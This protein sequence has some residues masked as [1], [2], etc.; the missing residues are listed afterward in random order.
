MV[1][2]PSHQIVKPRSLSSQHNHGIGLEVVAVVIH[3][4][5]LVEADA[6]EVALLQGFQRANEINDAREAQVLGGASRGLNGDRAK[7]SR[8]SLGKHNAIDASSLGSP[9][10][11]AQILRILDA[12]EG[13]HQPGFR[14]IKQVFDPQKIALPHNSHHP[15]VA[16]RTSQASKRLARLFANLNPRSPAKVQDLIE[17]A[18]VA[19]AEPFAR[20]AN[21]AEAP[22]A[23]TE[24]LLDRM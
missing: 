11:R 4:T 16:R 10:K 7:R 23:G 9:Q 5:A 18:R 20:N 21:V 24:C 13:Q 15:L 3:V 14:A 12:I 6:P 1:T 17:T 2:S 8:T 19:M 22:A